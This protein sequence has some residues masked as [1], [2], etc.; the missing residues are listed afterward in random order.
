VYLRCT[1][2]LFLE[3]V[4]L[5]PDDPGIQWA[6]TGNRISAAAGQICKPLPAALLVEP[7][8]RPQGQRENRTHGA[9]RASHMA[10]PCQAIARTMRSA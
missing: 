8:R 2:T 4:R 9:G 3:S 1:R 7:Q 10:A 5:L 6:A